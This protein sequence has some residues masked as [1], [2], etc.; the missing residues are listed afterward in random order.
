MAR[1]DDDA[2]SWGDDDP[3]LDTGAAEEPDEWDEKPATALP[4]AA[5]RRTVTAVVTNPD[6]STSTREVVHPHADDRRA[7]TKPKA[8][9]DTAPAP[10]GNVALVLFGVLGGVYALFAVGW[11]LAGSRYYGF[12]Y[13]SVEPAGYIAAWALATAAPVAWFA[14]VLVLAAKRPVW[15]RLVLL[16]VGALVLLP[17]PFLSTGVPA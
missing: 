2:L 12:A 1:R 7:S 14:A 17:W 3:T 4:T 15:L 10:L 13:F 9:A 5:P 11:Y 6:G 8:D 16:V